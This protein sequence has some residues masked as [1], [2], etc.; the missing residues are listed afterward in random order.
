MPKHLDLIRTKREEHIRKVQAAVHERLSQAITYWDRRAQELREKERRGK[1]N[2]RLNASQADD[3]ARE[4]QD[5]LQQRTA[6][7]DAARVLNPLP[8]RPVG[9]ALIIPIGMLISTEPT[10]A[11]RQNRLTEAIA[12][13]AVMDYELSLGNDPHDVSSVKCGYD[14]E[15]RDRQTGMLR[16]IEVKG[17]YADTQSVVLTHNE[18]LT[19]LNQPDHYYLAFVEVADGKARKVYYLKPPVSDPGKYAESVV[20]DWTRLIALAEQVYP[21]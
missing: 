14:I 20:F 6:E 7:L 21:V 17:R 10:D 1:T 13:R 15:S 16:L 9:R 2:A 12:M 3:K 8:P 18:I 19:A 4:L 11:L 5:R